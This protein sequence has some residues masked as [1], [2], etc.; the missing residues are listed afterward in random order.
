MAKN[1]AFI[2]PEAINAGG[3]LIASDLLQLSVT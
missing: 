2:E 3:C 1:P